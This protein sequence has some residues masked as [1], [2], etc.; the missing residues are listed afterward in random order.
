MWRAS[1]LADARPR[2]NALS[3]GRFQLQIQI[4]AVLECAIGRSSRSSEAATCLRRLL[5]GRKAENEA[6]RALFSSTPLSTRERTL[7]TLQK[8]CGENAERARRQPTSIRSSAFDY[9]AV[10]HLASSR[11]FPRS[12]REESVVI[13]I[14]ARSARRER[15]RPETGTRA[16]APVARASPPRPGPAQTGTRFP[17]SRPRNGRRGP[18]RSTGAQVSLRGPHVSSLAAVKGIAAHLSFCCRNATPRLQ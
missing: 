7:D 8:Q 18:E 17:P 12:E 4:C 3:P 6:R 15:R 16:L 10:F 9:G 14:N 5:I 1:G 11:G 2:K 13:G